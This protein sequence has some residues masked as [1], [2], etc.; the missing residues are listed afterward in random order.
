MIV[1]STEERIIGSVLDIP[2]FEEGASR[3][4]RAKIK[5]VATE[6]EYIADALSDPNCPEE[7]KPLL[8]LTG[9]TDLFWYEVQP[10]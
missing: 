8:I 9:R 3:F 1:E 6:A 4:V 10:D 7:T 5:R 2:E